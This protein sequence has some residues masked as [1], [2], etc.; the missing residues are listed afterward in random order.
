MSF[1]LSFFI[2]PSIVVISIQ[3][4]SVKMNPS[5]WFSVSRVWKQSFISGFLDINFMT[6]NDWT[7]IGFDII[8]VQNEL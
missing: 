3:I 4:Y 1:Q 5:K 7:W 8:L 2:M 6:L